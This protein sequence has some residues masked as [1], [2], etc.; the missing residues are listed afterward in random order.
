MDTQIIL[1]NPVKLQIVISSDGNCGIW[2]ENE[3]IKKENV[4][5]NL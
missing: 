1:S 3:Q 4:W 2:G 5:S